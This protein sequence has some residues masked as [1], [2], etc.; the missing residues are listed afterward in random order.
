[1][2]EATYDEKFRGDWRP[3]CLQIKNQLANQIHTELKSGEACRK[4]CSVES[5]KSHWTA[6]EDYS[7][8]HPLVDLYVNVCGIVESLEARSRAAD[9]LSEEELSKLSARLSG[10]GKS[11]QQ[12]VHR[13]QFGIEVDYELSKMRSRPKNVAGLFCERPGMIVVLSD[14]NRGET[15]MTL[16]HE[17][18]HV[19]LAG[20]LDFRSSLDPAGAISAFNTLISQMNKKEGSQRGFNKFKRDFNPTVVVDETH[21]EVLAQLHNSL[22]SLAQGGE[23]CYLAELATAGYFI[24]SVTNHLTS[25]CTKVYN[26][27]YQD[28]IARTSRDIGGLFKKQVTALRQAHF[29]GTLISP[30][31]VREVEALAIALLP[32][33]WHHIDSYLEYRFSRDSIQP[34]REAFWILEGR[35]Q[36]GERECHLLRELPSQELNAPYK[37]K[38]KRILFEQRFGPNGWRLRRSGGY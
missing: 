13:T 33:Q 19:L 27:R 22:D 29:I 17:R 24:Q 10:F 31:C 3:E 21:E 32:S 36:V 38:L 37:T 15:E 6:L 4:V 30:E 1:V 14:G 9:G 16:R 34:K 11:G 23:N 26:Q 18:V 8:A 35:T 28:E 7:D 20:A 25:Q 5:G 12:R 2:L